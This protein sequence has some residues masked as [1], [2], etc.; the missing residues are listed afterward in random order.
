M[1]QAA[2][3]SVVEK[4]R[5]TGASLPFGL[6]NLEDWS[7]MLG[8]SEPLLWVVFAPKRGLNEVEIDFLMNVD[9][10]KKPHAA[11]LG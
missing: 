5:S 3:Y 9:F 2:A 4:L 11:S 8:V 7:A 1:T 10:V 6:L